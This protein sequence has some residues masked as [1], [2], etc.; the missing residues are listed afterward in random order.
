MH[1]SDVKVKERILAEQP[2]SLTAPA[3][4]HCPA[5]TSHLCRGIPDAHLEELF[6]TSAKVHLKPG[7]TLILDGDEAL[8]TYNVIS[9]TMRLTRLGS[10]GRRQILAF[11]F[12]GNYIGLTADQTYHFNAEAVT[13][14][15]LC[16]FDRKRLDTLFRLHPDMEKEFRQ[17]AGKI[18]ETAN[19][20]LFTL[21]R[22]TA[23]ERVATFL[24]F[25]MDAQRVPCEAAP[26]QRRVS[27][28]MT[29]T[30]IADYLGLTIETVSR[31]IS[32][33]KR[34]KVIH[35]ASAHEI[36]ITSYPRLRRLA[37]AEVE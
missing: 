25:L 28:P 19:E 15:E 1:A 23:V 26:E 33:L 34:D 5:R 35:L 36:E 18:L 13:D 30:D 22:R 3:C 2:R 37:A 24:L 9:G 20:L 29:R 14:V 7:E 17:M 11:L 31:A 10:D 32:K 6:A 12:T 4:F 21:G 16:A 8:T 27:V